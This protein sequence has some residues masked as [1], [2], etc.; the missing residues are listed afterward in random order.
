MPPEVFDTLSDKDQKQ[1]FELKKAYDKKHP[2][3]YHLP[4]VTGRVDPIT[5]KTLFKKSE[6]GEW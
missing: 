4:V 1:W 5:G 2:P 6:V 3:V